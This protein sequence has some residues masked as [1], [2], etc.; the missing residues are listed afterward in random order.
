MAD[1]SNP[2]V[3][4]PANTVTPPNLYTP[5][6]LASVFDDGKYDISNYSYPADLYS[7]KGE[8]GGNYVIFYI[9]VSQDSKFDKKFNGATVPNL[10]PRDQGDL[11]GQN[12][13]QNLAGANAVAGVVTGVVAGGLFKGNV[14]GGVQGAVL[15][16]VGG[17]AVGAALQASGTT[18]ANK[19][20]KSA[21]ALHIPNDLSIS[22]GVQWSEEDTAALAMGAAFANAAGNGAAEIM[23]A[24]QKNNDS[25]ATGAVKKLGGTGAAILGNLALSQGPNG[26]A[27]SA[28]LGLTANPKKEQVFKGVDFRTFSFNYKFFPR[29]STEAKHVIDI[30]QMFKFHMHPEF[31][32]SNNFLY[33]YPSEFDIFYY[34]GGQENLNLHRHTSSV[35]TNMHINY[36]PNGMFTTFDDGMPTQIDVQ[37]QFRELALLT[38]DKV[39]DGL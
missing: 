5:R 27:N 3:A 37:L 33:I 36:T 2:P 10:T 15:G 28:A 17:A 19:R 8:Y 39:K 25:D 7:N 12:V 13:G 35:L 22:Y 29:N 26:A 11:V 21:I 14:E 34:Q 20:L 31:K 23:K 24:L 38:K 16:G 1:T 18:R 32:D 4:P 9:N 30:I 6:G